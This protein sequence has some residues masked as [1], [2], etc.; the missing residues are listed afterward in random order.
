MISHDN[1]AKNLIPIRRH[2]K[3]RQRVNYYQTECLDCELVLSIRWE[4]EYT[5]ILPSKLF[6]IRTKLKICPFCESSHIKVSPI[7]ESEYRNISQQWSAVD[8]AE[9]PQNDLDDWL[10]WLR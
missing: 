3:I 8:K 4:R 2:K 5:G 10:S 9:K 7:T 1:G 6:Q